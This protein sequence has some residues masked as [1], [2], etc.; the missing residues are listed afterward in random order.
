[1]AK[2]PPKRKRQQSASARPVKKA[3]VEKKGRSKQK[4]QPVKNKAREENQSPA[5]QVSSRKRTVVQWA[6]PENINDTH[7]TAL[8]LFIF[9]SDWY[10]LENALNGTYLPLPAIRSPFYEKNRAKPYQLDEKTDKNRSSDLLRDFYNDI[11]RQT[12]R[13]IDKDQYSRQKILDLFNNGNDDIAVVANAH[14]GGPVVLEDN[15][16]VVG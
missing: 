2:M 11:A 14:R 6:Y 13:Q 9:Q 8:A 12:Q 4:S 5:K 3:K 1:M 15:S 10:S 7:L 16:H